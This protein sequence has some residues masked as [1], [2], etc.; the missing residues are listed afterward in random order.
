M[1]SHNLL[2]Y[3]LQNFS[4][5]NLYSNIPRSKSPIQAYAGSGQTKRFFSKCDLKSKAFIFQNPF[6]LLVP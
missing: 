2:F 3:Q 5:I 6:F 1:F 4:I